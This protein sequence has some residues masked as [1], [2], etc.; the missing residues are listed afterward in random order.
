MK[1]CNIFVPILYKRETEKT[2]VGMAAPLDNFK[3][4]KC[5][6]LQAWLLLVI[7]QKQ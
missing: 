2:N 4:N 1:I 5:I 3:I 7:T 6:N